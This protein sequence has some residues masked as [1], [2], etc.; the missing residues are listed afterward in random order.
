MLSWTTYIKKEK[1]NILWLC[2]SH[3]Y[4]LLQPCYYRRLIKH[5]LI[6]VYRTIPRRLWMLYFRPGY[7]VTANLSK[8]QTVIKLSKVG[9]SKALEHMLMSFESWRKS[10]V[11]VCVTWILFSSLKIAMYI[12]CGNAQPTIESG[13]EIIFT[14]YVNRTHPGG[15]GGWRLAQ[16]LKGYKRRCPRNWGT[17][18]RGKKFIRIYC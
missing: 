16:Q 2:A 15:V 18:W 6:K 5:N 4:G 9:V 7:I 10:S 17:L 12:L 13:G 8:S 3:Q 14:K 11:I 1:N